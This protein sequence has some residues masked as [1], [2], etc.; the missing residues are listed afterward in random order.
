[1]VSSPPPAPPAEPP[2]PPPFFWRYSSSQPSNNSS[3]FSLCNNDQVS[4]S[5][6]LN[7]FCEQQLK[8]MVSITKR[9][10]FPLQKYCISYSCMSTITILLFY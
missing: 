6:I 7:P 2:L 4:L 5:I 3:Q 9:I 10:L 1:V 8:N